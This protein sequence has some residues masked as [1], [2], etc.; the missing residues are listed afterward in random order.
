M[1]YGDVLN[2]G[3]PSDNTI[4]TAKL[5]ANAVTTAKITD[6]NVTAA[7]IASGVVPS[8]RPNALPLIV[9]GNMAIS[10][11]STSVT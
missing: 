1:V 2:I 10:E 5:Q 7:K 3:T 6:G 8:L 9:N 11:R 4:S